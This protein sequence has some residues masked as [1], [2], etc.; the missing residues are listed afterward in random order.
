[1][2]VKYDLVEGVSEDEFR[3]EVKSV[4]ELAVDDSYRMADDEDIRAVENILDVRSGTLSGLPFYIKKA[5][6]E[7][8]G[9][10]T[11]MKDVVKT[12]IE[13]AHHSKSAILHTLLGNKYIVDRP[14][15]IR[16]SN[17]DNVLEVAGSYATIMY[18]CSSNLA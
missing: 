1:M 16:C 2:T 14:K 11:E 9:K 8:C 4:E 13:D 10:P 17:C 18:G 3:S 7:K 6:C 5:E 15:H 12:A